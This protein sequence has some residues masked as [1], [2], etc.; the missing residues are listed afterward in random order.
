MVLITS[1]HTV[2]LI[3]SVSVNGDCSPKSTVMYFFLS[4]G[5][6]DP[7]VIN[8]F[9]NIMCMC[10]NF[11]HHREKTERVK[12]CVELDISSLRFKHLLLGFF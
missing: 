5:A 12:V 9:F 1:T 4:V 6:H 8:N 2:V 11:L 10:S 3:S 7:T